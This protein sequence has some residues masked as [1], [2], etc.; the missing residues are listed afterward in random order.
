M[1]DQNLSICIIVVDSMRAD[2]LSCYGYKKK[3][4]PNIDTI[5][6]DSLVFQNAI[7]QSNGTFRSMYSLISGKYPIQHGIKWFDQR[8]NEAFV[9]LPEILQKHGYHTTIFSS[10][11]SL[12]NPS[13]FGGHFRERRLTY[14]NEDTLRFMTNRFKNNKK[15]FSIFHIGDYVHEPYYA[16]K[17]YVD[18]FYEGGYEGLE[19]DDT[20]NALTSLELRNLAEPM[21]DIIRKLN[22][23]TRRLTKKQLSYIIACYDAGIYYVDMFIGKFYEI[24]KSENKNYLFII[25][26]DHGQCFFEHG[27]HGH[28][29]HLYD[30]VIRVPLIFNMND[31][32]RNVIDE[33]VQHIDLYPTL[34]EILELKSEIKNL[35]GISLS[36]F[37]SQQKVESSNRIAISE[38]HPFISIREKNYK[39][40]TTH[41]RLEKYKGILRALFSNLRNKRIRRF[42]FNIYALFSSDKLYNL[43]NDPKEK[44]NIKNKEKTIYRQLREKLEIIFNN[45]QKKNAEPLNLDIDDEIKRQL[46]NLGYM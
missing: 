5:S 22:M 20:L 2:H 13:T 46:K 18:M 30:E 1:I 11:R 6:E 37:F 35:D 7:A 43:N 8:I 32:R 45:V 41:F 34:L 3:T 27:F 38:S 15:T 31:G 44:N 26:A 4:S 9:T 25:T 12:I 16:D 19:F 10:F 24:F 33:P 21:K 17:R 14:I 40:I 36:P 23:H 42:L 39:L 29:L 28:G